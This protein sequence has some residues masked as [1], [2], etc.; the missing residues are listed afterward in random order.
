MSTIYI[1]LFLNKW[2][3]KASIHVKHSYPIKHPLVGCITLLDSDISKRYHFAYVPI[4]YI[5]ISFPSLFMPQRSHFWPI[6]WSVVN[7]WA[8]GLV[9]CRGFYCCPFLGLENISIGSAS[10]PNASLDPRCLSLDC[11]WQLLIQGCCS[12]LEAIWIPRDIWKCPKAFLVVTTEEGGTI[13]I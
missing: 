12:Q 13:G 8:W 9:R 6:K 5:F 11:V 2:E 3:Y 7:L 1:I 10:V 4:N